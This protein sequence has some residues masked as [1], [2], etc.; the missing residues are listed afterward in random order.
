METSSLVAC[1]V[2][3]IATVFGSMMMLGEAAEVLGASAHVANTPA[4]QMEFWS[5][6]FGG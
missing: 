1:V 2:F 5:R 3:L 4:G 6:V